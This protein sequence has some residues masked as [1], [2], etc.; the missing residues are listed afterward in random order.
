M[1]RHRSVRSS[2]SLPED[3]DTRYDGSF[4]DMCC[5]RFLRPT[6][7][8]D[9]L[10]CIFVC[11]RAGGYSSHFVEPICRDIGEHMVDDAG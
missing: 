1:E 2:S 11:A 6:Q 4:L 5:W 10:K 8:R 9:L 7:G 3:G